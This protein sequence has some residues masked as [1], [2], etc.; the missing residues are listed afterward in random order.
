MKKPKEKVI[1]EIT[2]YFPKV[3]AAVIKLKA[4]LTI[5]DA[6]RIKGHTTDFKQ[7]VTSMQIDHVTIDQAKKGEEIGLLADSRVRQHDIVYKA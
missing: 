7:S 3:R 6:V 1:G 2:H 4:P 5:G